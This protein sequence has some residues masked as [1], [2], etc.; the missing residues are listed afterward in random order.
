MCVAETLF[1]TKSV[2]DSTCYSFYS[3]C[4]THL[5]LRAND[6]GTNSTFIYFFIQTLFMVSKQAKLKLKVIY[7]LQLSSR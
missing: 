1:D 4:Q 7:S 2:R 5:T 3:F 6:D